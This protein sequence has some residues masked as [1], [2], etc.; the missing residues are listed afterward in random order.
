MADRNI[1]PIP[2]H[3]PSDL[4]GMVDLKIININQIMAFRLWVSDYVK[5]LMEAQSHI[6][7][8]HYITVNGYQCYRGIN[9]FETYLTKY[10]PVSVFL[11]HLGFTDDDIQGMIDFRDQPKEQFISYIW[12]PTMTANKEDFDFWIT[13]LQGE[14]G[15]VSRIEVHQTAVSYR[16]SEVPDEVDRLPKSITDLGYI[17]H[18]TDAIEDDSSIPYDEQVEPIGLEYRHKSQYLYHNVVFKFFDSNDNEMQLSD[19]VTLAIKMVSIISM[20]DVVTSGSLTKVGEIERNTADGKYWQIEAVEEVTLNLASAKYES[21]LCD[22]ET[23]DCYWEEGQYGEELLGDYYGAYFWQSRDEV[24]QHEDPVNNDIGMFEYR[25]SD[26]LYYLRVDFEKFANPDEIGYL[27]TKF[28]Y[29]DAYTDEGS[30]FAKFVKGVIG[31]ALVVTGAWL[32]FSTFGSSAPLSRKLWSLSSLIIGTTTRTITRIEN[33]ELIEQA[34]KQAQETAR[35]REEMMLEEGF[36]KNRI[37]LSGLTK[38]PTSLNP[39]ELKLYNPFRELE[40]PK[41]DYYIGGEFWNPHA[42]LT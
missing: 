34:Q 32:F 3:N 37:D 31:M 14:L 36:L 9:E 24:L 18:G 40:L 13:Y 8:S 2:I 28:S 33:R 17:I 5:L 38:I 25:A 22:D 15:N 23:I 21:Y 6:G 20:D 19:E 41:N 12:N 7:Q 30:D 29:I 1:N 42:K 35:L 39:F 16:D 10:D 4:G 27:I 11:K 26:G